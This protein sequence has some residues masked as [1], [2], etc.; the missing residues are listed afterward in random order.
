MK[1]RTTL[2]SAPAVN[3][4]KRPQQQGQLPFLQLSFKLSKANRFLKFSSPTSSFSLRKSSSAKEKLAIS[5]PVKSNITRPSVSLNY[6]II[7]FII[8]AAETPYASDSSETRGIFRVWPNRRRPTLPAPNTDS[9]N[10][11]ASAYPRQHNSR[12][13]R[14]PQQHRFLQLESA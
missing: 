1:I 11:P 3:H 7:S 9:N 13:R 4:P 12:F 2:Y 8:H 10:V 14:N 5:T 6:P